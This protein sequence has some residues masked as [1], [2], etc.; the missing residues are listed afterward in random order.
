MARHD[1]SDNVVLVTGGARGIGYA[2]AEALLRRGARVMIVDLEDK[3]PKAAAERLHRDRAAGVVA[4]IADREAIQRA[5][6]ET[7]RHFGRIDVLVANAGVGT[8]GATFR[9]MPVETFRRVLDVDLHGTIHTVDCALPHIIRSRGHIVI[10]SS[11]YAFLNGT[12]AVPYSIAKAGIEQLGRALRVELARHGAN[13]GVAY[14]GF[15]STDMVREMVDQD[16]LG[17]AAQTIMPR[18]MRKR[19]SAKAAGEAIARG[20]E[21]RSARII[22]PRRWAL[23]QFFRGI[24]NPV[25]DEWLRRN[26]DLRPLLYEFDTRGDAR[27]VP[28]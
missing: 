19:A 16:P 22:V 13:A 2:T 11:A 6:D 12:G 14:F 4:D 7:V 15:V 1:V 20:I 9:A 17:D 10:V 28:E 21:R 25:S 24:I 18:P 5:V 23:L 27:P 26:K 3:D 8:Q